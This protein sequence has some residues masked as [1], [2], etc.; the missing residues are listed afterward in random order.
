MISNEEIIKTLESS[1]GMRKNES[2][3]YLDL[4]HSGSSSVIDISKRI[5]MHRPNVYDLLDKLFK[6]GIVKI[7]TIGKKKVFTAIPPKDLLK[8]HKEKEYEL[9]KTIP[10]I[11]KRHNSSS[12]ENDI[13]MTEGIRSIK[14][15]IDNLLEINKPI[16]TYGIPK[17]VP[18]V[19]GGFIHDFHKKRIEKKIP[20][21][22]IYNFDAEK[23]IKQLNKMPYTKAKYL[24]SLYNTKI[25]TTICGDTVYFWIWEP[26]YTNII[27]KNKE[28]AKTYKSYFKILWRESIGSSSDKIEK[29]DE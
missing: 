15:T 7:T 11:E 18:E 20:Q 14:A 24:P 9:E 17:E 6:D 10:E 12:K 13:S 21:Y 26:P 2:L 27:I 4:V 25:D 28:I 5:K 16:Y 8:Y 29:I 19:L 22:H 3:I 1:I 23:R